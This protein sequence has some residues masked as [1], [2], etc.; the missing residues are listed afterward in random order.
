[1]LTEQLLNPMQHI[2][3][4]GAGPVYFATM[5]AEVKVLVSLGYVGRDAVSKAC[6][7]YLYQWAVALDAAGKQLLCIKLQ[8]RQQLTQLLQVCI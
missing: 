2:G 6:R 5:A 8:Q 4:M 7:I 1:L 3:M